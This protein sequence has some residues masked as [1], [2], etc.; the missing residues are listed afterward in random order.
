LSA[1]DLSGR[2]GSG[3][4]GRASSSRGARS[5]SARYPK[6]K[7][8][9]G[10]SAKDVAAHQRDRLRKAM[11]ELVAEQG[12][13]AVA[14]SALSNH[15][16]VSKREFYKHFDSKEECFLA[17]YDLIVSHSL[18]GILAAVEGEEDWCER[19]R[20]GFHAFAGQIASK[21]EEARLALV[22]VFAAGAVA[23]E[24]M[25]H[26]NRLFEE[27][28]AQSLVLADGSSRLP[29]LVVKG[30]VAG[31]ARVARARLLSGDPRQLTLDGDELLDWVLCFCGGNAI[32][33]RRPEVVAAAPLPATAACGD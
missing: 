18:R 19:L 30:I 8:G 24:R 23:V 33:L 27:L 10:R 5:R 29:P 21:P 15:A 9:P 12:Y 1:N 3:P 17:T 32:R 25:L 28:I 7:P 4:N 20:L 22:E 14:V 2:A 26:T 31:G 13:N 16:G 6:L 11:V